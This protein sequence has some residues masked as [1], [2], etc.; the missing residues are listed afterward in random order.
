MRRKRDADAFLPLGKID[1]NGTDLSGLLAEYLGDLKSS[2]AGETRSIQSSG[3]TR[4][5]PELYGSVLH[6]QTGMV[7]GTGLPPGAP[8][9]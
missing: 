2:D 4:H 7:A 5:G 6:G 3:V 1:G 8:R 9:W